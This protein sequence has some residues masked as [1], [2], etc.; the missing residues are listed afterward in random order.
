[1]SIRLNR[2][3]FEK[4]LNK[5]SSYWKS[6]SQ[7]G[8]FKG[9][10]A[11]LFPVGQSDS[12]QRISAFQVWLF[13][14]ELPDVVIA[15]CEDTLHILASGKKVDLLKQI[16]PAAGASSETKVVLHVRSKEDQDKSNFT[17]ICECI[18][19][20]KNGKKVGVISKDSFQ[21]SFIQ[22]WTTFSKSQDFEEVD[23]SMAISVIMS[24]KD[25]EEIASVKESAELATAVMKTYFI[26]E[27]EQIIDSEKK[28]T[29][30]A[31][32]ESTEAAILDPEKWKVS[33]TQDNVDSVYTPIVQSGGIYDLKPSA[34]SD[35]RELHFGTILCSIGCRNKSYCS[36][37]S[38]TILVDPTKTQEKN[39]K[40]LL[41]ARSAVLK[42]LKPGTELSSLYE[43]AL[44]VIRKHNSELVSNFTPSIGFGMGL[45]FR[46]AP[47]LINAKNKRQVQN[48]MVFNLSL[49]FSDLK[50][51]NTTD[52]KS[53]T[54]S[55]LVADTVAVLDR[56]ARVLTPAPLLFP[57]IS[58]FFKDPDDKSDDDKENLVVEPLDAK[59]RAV[60]ESRLRGEERT[61]KSSDESRREHQ[62]E[63][64]ERL[65]QE[66][67]KRIL[68]SS[69]NTSGTV[70]SKAVRISYQNSA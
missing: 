31:L 5:I 20:S 9:A 47:L 18:R 16:Q 17:T 7:D 32:A 8:I 38:R 36:N 24:V 44:S 41:E 49:G 10:D 14:Y 25:Q 15:L 11:L 42:K 66:A 22:S 30:S 63:L 37:I 4:R 12:F 45:E 61:E 65:H 59:G 3:V 34:S 26:N 35:D 23:I 56:E 2:T 70:S 53:E 57:D 33:A 21:G 60:I 39:Y 46:E 43:S 48:G 67:Q 1:M 19:K 55:L 51:S 64:A 62:A 13:G 6:A 29:H 58:Y 69:T 68:A 27:L 40:I 54:Y 50:E 52:P 28:I